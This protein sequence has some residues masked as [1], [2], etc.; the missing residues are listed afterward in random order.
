MP[1]PGGSKGPTGDPTSPLGR[2][3]NGE[4][5]SADIGHS[6]VGGDPSE[7]RESLLALENLPPSAFSHAN[8]CCEQANP[9]ATVV[10]PT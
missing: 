3:A 9:L 7:A 2:R 8:M 10:G 1:K 4:K 6:K 5:M